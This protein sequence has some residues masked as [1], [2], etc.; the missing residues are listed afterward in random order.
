MKKRL[1]RILT[2][3]LASAMLCTGLPANAL[4]AA[5]VTSETEEVQERPDTDINTDADAGQENTEENNTS[6]S[7]TGN[8]ENGIASDNGQQEDPVPADEQNTDEI[9]SADTDTPV[10]NDAEKNDLANS[11]R[12]KNGE[13]ILSNG[14]VTTFSA[15]AGG[16]WSEKDGLFYN[17][18]GEVISGAVAKGI[19]VSQWNGNINWAKVKNTDVDY[20]MIRCGYGM[21]EVGQDDTMWKKNADACTANGI[22]F[23]TYLYSYADTVA[24]AK[25]EAEHVLRLVEGYDLAYPIYYDLEETNI[26]N[27]LTK[28]QIAQIA[29]TFCDT[30]RAAGYKVGVYANLDWFNNYLTDPVFDNYERWVAQWNHSCTYKGDYAMWQCTNAGSVDGITGPV[31]LDFSMVKTYDQVPVVVDDLDIIS[32]STHQQTYGWD[33]EKQNGYQSGY[34]GYSRRLEALKI[35]VGE[36]YTN[37]GVKYQVHAQTYGWMDPVENGEIAGTTGESKRIEAI[38]IELTGSEKDNYNIYYRVHSQTYGWLD[39]ASNG[40]PAGTLGYSKRA[41]AIQIAVLPKS[42]GAPGE[43]A[44]PYVKA[45]MAL[46]YSTYVNGQGWQAVSSDG[47]TNGTTGQSLSV[48]AL[49][50][51]VINADYDCVGSIEYE[52]YMQGQGWQNSIK[53]DNAEAGIPGGGKRMEAMR[54]RLTG[55]LAKKYD[56]YYRAYVQT[57]GWLDWA[58]NW[59]SAGTF[60]Y[61]KRLEAIQVKLVAKDAEGNSQAPGE[62]AQPSMQAL[63]KYQTHVQTYGWKAY[64]FDGDINGT[65]GLSKRL[66]AIKIVFADKKNLDQIRYRTHVQ[67]YGWQDWVNGDELSGTEGQSKRMEALQ[68]E[69]TGS[70]AEKYDIYYRLHVQTYG[71]LDW[72]KNGEKA[73]TEGLSKR[74]EAI[75]IQLVEKGGKAPGSTARPFVEAE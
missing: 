31:D 33:E 32:Y 1:E 46:Q 23:G 64:G 16:A 47:N 66:E 41:E 57:Y 20:A 60:D 38:R 2:I 9:Q 53:K 74:A 25:S 69:L 14:G 70:M 42:A 45:D 36:K 24:R 62:T 7:S 18:R 10:S 72:A 73:G 30:I 55:D 71:W 21:D 68:I 58:T 8:L 61:A 51:K 19:D 48:E 56:V 40:Q 5:E 52:A 6:D 54:M 44:N 65:T 13:R 35:N 49:K 4:Q 11:W 26:R 39:W 27:K 67:T 17:D 12:F 75:Q 34:T 43:T 59:Q 29:K 3:L 28:A 37:L 63:I 15:R 50:A 22:P